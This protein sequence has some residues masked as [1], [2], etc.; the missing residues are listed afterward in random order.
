MGILYENPRYYEIAFGFRNIVEEVDAIEDMIARYSDISVCRVL[1]IA[2]GNAPY[3]EELSARGYQYS[4]LD[5]SRDML[6]YARRKAEQSGLDIRLIEA[7]MTNFSLDAP[8]DFACLLLGSI[9]LKSPA[10]FTA[11]LDA[12][13]SALAP[14]GLYLLD[15]CVQ[16]EPVTDLEESWEAEEDG[17][18]IDVAYSATPLNLLQQTYEEQILFQIHDRGKEKEIREHAVKLA[19]YPQEFLLRVAAHPAFE[20]I[21][22]WNEWD[23][24]QPLDGNEAQ[25]NRPIILLKR[26][27]PNA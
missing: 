5:L 15:W 23:L 19:I 10:E 2:C 21:G 24:S 25:I 14:G 9:Y 18:H 1:E 17:I 16:F 22:W 27:A 6:A 3:M 7:E 4:G 20:F 8:V 26:V 13:G 12:V 11:H